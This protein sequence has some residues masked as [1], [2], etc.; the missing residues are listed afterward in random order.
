MSSNRSK[1][2]SIKRWIFLFVSLT[3]VQF[4][5][6]YGVDRFL[7]PPSLQHS[8]TSQPS[9]SQSADE[10]VVAPY[11]AVQSVAT[12]D[13]RHI[14]YTTNDDRLFVEGKEGI[15]FAEN[16][17]KVVFMQWLGRSNT[18]VYFV[19]DTSLKGYLLRLN[20]S[21]PVEVHQWLGTNRE[22][23][24]IYFSPYLEFFYIEMKNS[25]TDGSEV[26]KYKAS[27]GIKKL[28][29]GGLEIEHMD[30]DPKADIM[31]MTTKYG[32]KWMY[33][34]DRLRPLDDAGVDQSQ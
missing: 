11:N 13:K 15:S 4:G 1:W 22:V 25:Q 18:L 16:V 10:T 24:N 6:L 14:A 2:F 9:S 31:T 26:Y 32:E 33:K 17:G 8:T 12:E 21:E 27:G 34:N 3:I 5:S 20:S 7:Q 28:P 23:K 30:Y 19:Q 29:L